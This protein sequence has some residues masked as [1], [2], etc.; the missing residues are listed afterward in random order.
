M[1]TQTLQQFSMSEL[2]ALVRIILKLPDASVIYGEESGSVDG[3]AYVYLRAGH[4][5][6]FGCARRK[7]INATTEVVSSPKL[8]EVHITAVGGNAWELMSKLQLVLQ[9]SPA[10][11][12]FHACGWGLMTMKKCPNVGH[13]MGAGFEQRHRITLEISYVHKVAI[14]Q[15][16]I[17]EADIAVYTEL[18]ETQHI[19]VEVKP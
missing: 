17:S 16:T 10:K 9:S 1:D 4:L 19:H 18:E 7:Q 5:S 3:Q 12:H 2:R 15:D 11:S 13:I 14:E 6:D 8:Q